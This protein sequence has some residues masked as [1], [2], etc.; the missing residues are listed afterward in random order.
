MNTNLNPYAPPADAKPGRYDWSLGKRI[1]Y[2]CLV[3]ALMYLLPA[4][5]GFYQMYSNSALG[6]DKTLWQKLVDVAKD[7]NPN[8]NLMRT[9]QQ[10]E[11]RLPLPCNH[12]Q[13]QMD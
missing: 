7:W 1:F 13:N 4:T 12:T 5:V 2:A 11:R 3:L 6:R 9:P 10:L 8:L